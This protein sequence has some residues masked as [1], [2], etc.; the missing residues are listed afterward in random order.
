MFRLWLQAVLW[1]FR[2]AIETTMTN[3]FSVPAG[4]SER[5]AIFVLVAVDDVQTVVELK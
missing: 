5:V 1:M 4:G 3:V 2:Q